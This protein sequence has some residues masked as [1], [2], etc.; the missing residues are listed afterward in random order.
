[1][2]SE[3]SKGRMVKTPSEIYLPGDLLPYTLG[4]IIL[5]SWESA[6]D[7]EVEDG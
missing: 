5:K 4:G 2:L 3:I 1:M 6:E 7:A